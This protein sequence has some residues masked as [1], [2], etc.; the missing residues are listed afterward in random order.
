MSKSLYY[1]KSSF[2][3]FLED[4]IIPDP[5]EL[6]GR[7][8]KYLISKG[9]DVVLL[10]FDNNKTPIIM[11]DD[12]TYAFDKVFGCWQGAK[13]TKIN[14]N[15]LSDEPVSRKKKIEKYYKK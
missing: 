10:G 14:G 7:A 8:L 1:I 13:F 5:D 9:E 3:V 6:L 12:M 4:R 11:I 15:S 2:E